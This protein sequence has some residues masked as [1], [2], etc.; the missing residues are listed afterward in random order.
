MGG[1]PEPPSIEMNPLYLVGAMISHAQPARKQRPPTGVIAPSQRIFVNAMV[2]KLPL[3]RNI[4]T[5]STHHAP[6]LIVP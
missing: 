4:P 1:L 5:R 2:Y 3:K 6:R